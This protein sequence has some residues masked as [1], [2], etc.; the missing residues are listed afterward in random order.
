MVYIV[1]RRGNCK[2]ASVGLQCE[3]GL[4]SRTYYVLSGSVL[5]CWTK[6][7]SVLATLPGGHASRMQIIRL[8]T[9]DGT[10]IVGQSYNNT[11]I[12]IKILTVYYSKVLSGTLE[13]HIIEYMPGKNLKEIPI[14]V[15]LLGIQE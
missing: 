8:K 11:V 5:G 14:D 10:R 12:S 1:F 2:R 3:V 15:P 9:E 7:E 4:R 6:V 13:T